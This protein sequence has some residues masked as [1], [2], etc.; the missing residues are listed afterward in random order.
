MMRVS[1]IERLA[2]E[3]LTGWGGKVPPVNVES[4][5]REEGIA[6]A[7]GSYGED[8]CGRIEFHGDVGKFILFHPDLAL[9]PNSARVRFSIG[10]ELGHYFIEHHRDLLMAGRAHN[11]AS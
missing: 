9:A 1:E 2:S 5:A 11:S 4:I 8:F 10:H 6:L 7:P 3:V